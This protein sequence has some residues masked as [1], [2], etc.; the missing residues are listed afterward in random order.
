MKR[1]WMMWAALALLALG[2]A[3]AV[4]GPDQTTGAARPAVNEKT[5]RALLK[6][7][8]ENPGA[9]A[10]VLRHLLS[11]LGEEP[12]QAL[13]DVHAD[14]LARYPDFDREL[15]QWLTE[16]RQGRQHFRQRFPG[17]RSFVLERLAQL[18]DAPPRPGMFLR[19]KHRSLMLSL[20]LTAS[21]LVD[22]KYPELPERWHQRPTGVG[23]AAFLL[24]HYPQLVPEL[25]ERVTPEQR[26]ALRQA[27][28][29]FLTEREAWAKRQPPER[30]EQGFD[31]LLSRFPGIVDGWGQERASRRKAL[32][33]K[34]PDL[35]EVALESLGRRHPDLLL[36]AAASVDKHYPGLRGQVREALQQ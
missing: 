5:A 13:L 8:R 29:D 1:R 9:G 32:L 10:G 20:A 12:V 19:S 23:P 31:Q 11:D 16:S 25:I 17:L 22:E 35:R 26:A 14:I 33:E 6:I 24:E 36:R 2:S 27:L 34:F 3:Q 7:Q 21:R 18:K 28:V 4:P 15:A 30:L